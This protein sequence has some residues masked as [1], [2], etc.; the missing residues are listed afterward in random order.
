MSQTA[1]ILPGFLVPEE[2]YLAGGQPTAEQLRAAAAKGLQRVIDLRPESE[3]HGFDET[4]V[5]AHSGLAYAILPIAGPQDLTRDNA[6]RLDQ[7]LAEAGEETTLVHCASGNR[8]GALMALRAAWLQGQPVPAA[9]A[10]GK[11]WGLTRMEPLVAQLL[12]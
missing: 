11:R 6:Q 2:G 4:D 12:S 3:D 1:A 10:L 7:L 5:N 9:L 8:V